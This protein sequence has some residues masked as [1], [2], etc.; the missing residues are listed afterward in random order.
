MIRFQGFLFGARQV[1][2]LDEFQIAVQHGGFGFGMNPYNPV[3][4]RFMAESI[5]QRDLRFA[6]AAPAAQVL[7][8]GTSRKI[9]LKGI[10]QRFPANKG[11]VFRIRGIHK[12]WRG[13]GRVFFL[14]VCFADD[15]IYFCKNSGII[16][17]VFPQ[18]SVLLVNRVHQ[19]LYIVI[20]DIVY[21]TEDR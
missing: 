17:H 14:A 13:Q 19:R 7:G 8:L 10:Q 12:G 16:F 1:H 5:R 3:I 9:L 4:V 2:V 18:Y 15:F 20:T 21:Y 11:F 6:H